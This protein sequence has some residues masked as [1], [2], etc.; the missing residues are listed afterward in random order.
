MSQD[1]L[2]QQTGKSQTGKYLLQQFPSQEVRDE[3]GRYGGKRLPSRGEH[4]PDKIP[5]METIPCKD[6]AR[7]MDSLEVSEQNKN[8][9]EPTFLAHNSEKAT[10]GTYKIKEGQR[11]KG[12]DGNG[13]LEEFSKIFPRELVFFSASCLI[14]E[15]EWASVVNHT[16]S[17]GSPS[18]KENQRDCEKN[19]SVMFNG[20]DVCPMQ[21]DPDEPESFFP[22]TSDTIQQNLSLRK[23]KKNGLAKPAQ[24]AVLTQQ[25]WTQPR[26]NSRRMLKKLK[27]LIQK[28][29]ESWRLIMESQQSYNWCW[30]LSP[31]R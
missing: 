1:Y 21:V 27:W 19:T 8:I 4:A 20:P 16:I 10:S 2:A 15:E 25:K 29:R 30:I 12:K 26:E 11:C 17:V 5:L 14:S 9:K 28:R 13:D 24:I 31:K 6:P 23:Q 18:R 3:N 22:F 7:S